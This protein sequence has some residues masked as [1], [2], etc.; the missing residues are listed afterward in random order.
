MEI[1][2]TE[3]VEQALYECETLIAERERMRHQI[4]ELGDRILEWDDIIRRRHADIIDFTRRNGPPMQEES[5]AR[6]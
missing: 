1:N 3:D 2:N 4:K 6:Q 5:H